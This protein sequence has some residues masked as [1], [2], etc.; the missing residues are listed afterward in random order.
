M[1]EPV[2]DPMAFNVTTKDGEPVNTER[3]FTTLAKMLDRM[4]DDSMAQHV[5]E[6][7]T[8]PQEPDPASNNISTFAAWAEL[9]PTSWQTAVVSAAEL[10]WHE[11]PESKR[12]HEQWS[13]VL[14]QLFDVEREHK[15]KLKI[16]E[17]FEYIATSRAIAFGATLGF[18]MA[19]TWPAGVEDLDGWSA[20]AWEYA[21][22]DRLPAFGDEAKE[23]P[24]AA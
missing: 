4:I 21:G 17:D 19:R 3:L 20:R 10:A 15:V 9:L 2:P 5:K 22:L 23:P 14:D 24:A 16:E 12:L 7:H 18:A 11:H 1:A 8:E 13:T 6:H